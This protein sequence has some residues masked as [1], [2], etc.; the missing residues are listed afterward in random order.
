[1]EIKTDKDDYE[2]ETESYVCPYHRTHPNA[3]H[4]GCNCSASYTLKK[5]EKNKLME[6][7]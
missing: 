6:V 5:K 2:I 4:A 7:K 1:M 3:N